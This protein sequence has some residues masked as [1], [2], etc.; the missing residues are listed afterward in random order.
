VAPAPIESPTFSKCGF[1]R[2]SAILIADCVERSP[3]VY[4]I[5]KLDDLAVG[6]SNVR[7]ESHEYLTGYSL[8]D[9]YARSRAL[10]IWLLT[11]D[12]I[13]DCAPKA[14][15]GVGFAAAASDVFP[16]AIR[17]MMSDG[18]SEGSEA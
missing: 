13:S 6:R 2:K 15:G 4:L 7:G 14:P 12:A 5:F 16:K 18:G 10:L 9:G 8:L 1:E 11:W 17:L 3:A